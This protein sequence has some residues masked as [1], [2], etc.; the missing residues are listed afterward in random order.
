MQFDL[1]E[2]EKCE[3]FENCS[4]YYDEQGPPL[5]ATLLGAF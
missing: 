3:E 2:S 1:L 5:Y 4:E